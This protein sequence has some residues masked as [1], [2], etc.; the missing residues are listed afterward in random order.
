[1]CARIT[2]DLVDQQRQL[3]EDLAPGIRG[4]VV[5]VIQRLAR[6]ADARFRSG[7]AGACCAPDSD[8]VACT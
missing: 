2:S 4:A 8:G 5:Q 1:L 3:L 6:A 7:V